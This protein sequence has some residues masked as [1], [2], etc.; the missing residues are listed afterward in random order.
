MPYTAEH[1]MAADILAIQAMAGA[2]FNP[3]A[4]LIVWQN[5]TRDDDLNA[6][7]YI[8]THPHS[9]QYL[10]QL[11]ELVEQAMPHLLDEGHSKR[12]SRQRGCINHIEAFGPHF[13]HA[14]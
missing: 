5:M 7:S 1:E 6:S 10:N 14:T 9:P 3:S 4:A 11:S 8:R 13:I 2:G 12:I